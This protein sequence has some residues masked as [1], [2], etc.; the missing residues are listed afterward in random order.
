MVISFVFATIACIILGT[1]FLELFKLAIPAANGQ[2]MIGLVKGFSL[3]AVFM[4]LTLA[5]VHTCF[6]MTSL[7]TDQTLAWIGGHMNSALGAKH[8]QQADNVLVAGVSHG[9]G[10]V[11]AGITESMRK[12]GG[13]GDEKPDKTDNPPPPPPRG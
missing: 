3:I 9:R 6:G 11:N 7:I 5:L 12:G 10:G 2:S 13:R 4:S 8:D 1:I